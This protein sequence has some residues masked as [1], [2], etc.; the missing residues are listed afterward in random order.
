M[1]TLR[2]T[3][4]GLILIGTFEKKML[5]GYLCP[6]GVAT[7]GRGV[8][9]D[10][11]RD[12]GQ[13][14]RYTDGTVADRVIVGKHVTPDEEDR[15]FRAVVDFFENDVE[16]KLAGAKVNIVEPHEFDAMNSLAW[17]IGLGNFGKSSVLRLYRRGDKR[18]AAEAF[19]A[20]NKATVNGR[21]VVLK[22]LVRRR[23]A[24][25]MLFL[26][27]Y[28]AASALAEADL[29]PMP[30]R[31]EKPARREP[32]LKSPTGNSQLGIGGAGGLIAIE[33]ARQAV[34]AA[35]QARETAQ[36]AGELF[37]LSGSTAVMIG[38]GLIVLGLAG[39]AWW[40]R[41]RRSQVEDLVELDGA[42]DVRAVAA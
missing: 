20:W 23:A 1:S 14:I 8:T 13:S 38:G 32:V 18:G 4:S 28:R 29:G 15:V 37:G 42:V 33:G 3:A 26:G 22:G 34:D 35:R 31:V 2:T 11:L 5:K 39:Y 36:T 27:D 12:A 25:R 24:E 6:A 9:T 30:Q 17:N 40:R 21:K 10:A 7:I 41:F 16:R 19:L